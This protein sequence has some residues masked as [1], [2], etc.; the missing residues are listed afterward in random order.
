MDSEDDKESLNI[1]SLNIGRKTYSLLES[2]Y[3]I[4]YGDTD[5]VMY[6]NDNYPQM[7]MEEV[8]KDSKTMGDYV[9]STFPEF[10]QRF[11][12]TGGI[13][14]MK[15]EKIYDKW[16]QTGAKKRYGAHIVWKDKWLTEEDESIEIKGFEIRRS[17][18]TLYTHRV[19]EKMFRL[20]FQNI[21]EA[22]L[23]YATET[24]N[25][26]HQRIDIR[27]IGKFISL[28]RDLSTYANYQPARAI[29]NAEKAGIE[30][31]E[32]QGKYRMYYLHGKKGADDVICVNFDQELPTKYKNKLD[33]T[34]HKQICFDSIFEDIIDVVGLKPISQGEEIL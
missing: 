10:L 16:L 19:M 25:W 15:L 3:R 5:S 27:E 4:L 11:N 23:F 32:S 24:E 26:M 7:S 6:T 9:D 21:D 14:H 30:L 2:Q 8:L 22:R 28:Q 31:D 33:W 12:A 29:R 18:S 17:D 13:L 1:A 34:Y 20:I